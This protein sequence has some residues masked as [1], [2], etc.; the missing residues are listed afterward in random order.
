[1]I[2]HWV[3]LPDEGW[4][5]VFGDSSL[6]AYQL[7][8]VGG[9]LAGLYLEQ[10]H[11][12]LTGHKALVIL[13]VPVALVALLRNYYSHISSMGV[14]EASTPLQPMMIVWSVVTL[15]LLYL[16][17]DGFASMESATARAVF[18]YGAQ[19]SFGVYL[20]HPL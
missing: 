13:S 16:V 17:A 5:M 15:A 8:M 2:Y 20:V 19:L 11:D 12:W 9:A 3:T 18:G 4:R 10:I 6:F 7:W 1:S 14:L